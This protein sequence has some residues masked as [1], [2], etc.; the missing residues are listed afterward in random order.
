M[1]RDG[2]TNLSEF[3]LLYEG[4]IGRKGDRLVELPDGIGIF[5]RPAW[6]KDGGEACKISFTKLPNLDQLT[7]AHVLSAREIGHFGQ[8]EWGG[9][10]Q[11][12]LLRDGRIGVIG[13]VARINGGKKSYDAMS[14]IFDSKS[15]QVSDYQL[16][17]KY[18]QFPEVEA[19]TE[20]LSEVIY[21]GGRHTTSDGDMIYCGKYDSASVRGKRRRPI[22]ATA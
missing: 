17:A 12:E 19:K 3:T 15:G 22:F 11:L 13:H 2:G 6:D 4:I 7:Q 14:F 16:I 18:S 21:I 20:E 9:V 5:T 8:Q 10:N 1:Y